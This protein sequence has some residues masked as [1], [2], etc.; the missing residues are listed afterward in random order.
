MERRAKIVA[1][2]GPASSEPEVVARLIRAGV[3]VVRLNLSH[4][5]HDGHRERIRQVRAAAQE[6][7]R[8]VPVV[9]DLMGPRYRLGTLAERRELH[10]GERVRLGP[11]PGMDLPVEQDIL[12]LL[13][14]GERMLIDQGL[15]EL[16]VEER[17]HDVAVARTVSGG[18]VSTRKGINLPDSDLG[19]EITPKDRED[20]AFAVAEKVDYLAAS[21]VGRGEDLRDLRRLLAELGGSIPLIAKLERSRAVDNLEEIVAAADAVM[22]ARGDLGVEVPIHR[23]PVLQKRI[24]HAGRR[25]GKP[26]IVA[27]QMLES[28]M[29]QPRPTRAEATDVA[30][31]VF[32]G[33]DA[34]MLSGE[35]AAGR[36]PVESVEMMGRIIVE[37][38]QYQRRAFSSASDLQRSTTAPPAEA[39]GSVL[40]RLADTSVDVPDIVSAAAVYTAR[41]LGARRLVAFSQSGFTGRLVARYRPTTPISVFTLTPEVARRLGLVWSVEPVVLDEH[42]EHLDE[43]VEVVDRELIA[44][45]LAAPGDLIVVLMGAPIPERRQTNLMRVHRVRADLPRDADGY[46]HGGG[47]SRP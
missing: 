40:G 18:A 38:E 34:L 26:V 33:A 31:A 35:T 21:Y 36:H 19:F 45:G 9:L 44:R 1:T 28:M 5:T 43:V 23:V 46:D 29:E 15:V 47:R 30:N 11:E 24:V 8:H 42:P 27:T 17:G 22:V 41:E 4:G 14:P 32:D 16:E 3:D 25:A 37:A 6:A 39:I 13:H 10:E 2:F 7:G 20:V 12:D